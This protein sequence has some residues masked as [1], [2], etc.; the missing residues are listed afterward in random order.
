MYM[1]ESCLQSYRLRV[2][3]ARLTGWGTFVSDRV[4]VCGADALFR[5][6]CLLRDFCEDSR[7]L[8]GQM[9]FG[10]SSGSE[11]ARPAVS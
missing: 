3:M 4:F 1:R 5:D 10:I 11:N 7:T 6:Y 9:L 2:R 8:C